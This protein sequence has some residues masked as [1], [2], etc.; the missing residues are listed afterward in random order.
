M[1]L[2]SIKSLSPHL[3]NQ[4]A[5]GEVVDRPASVVKELLE[6]ALDADADKISLEIERGGMK[7][8]R[9]RDN[10]VGIS[11]Q[12]LHLALSRHATSKISSL[13]DLENVKSLGFRGEALPSIASI[14]RLKLSSRQKEAEQAWCLYGD[15]KEIF[16][17]PPEP[18]AHPHGTSL[19]IKDLFF[20]VPARR[21]FLKTEKTEFRHIE[22]VV[23]KIALSC[24]E[25]QFSLQHN[26]RSILHLLPATDQDSADKRVASVCGKAFS[27]QSFYFEHEAA[28][29]RLWGWVGLPTFSRAQADLQYFFVNGRVIR[30]RVVSHAVRQAYQDVLYHGRHPAYVLFL[31]LEP[32]LV[33]VNAHPRK[34]EVRFR[35]S[36]LVHSFL[37]RSLKQALADLR[38]E[39][40]INDMTEQQA[41]A[42]SIDCTGANSHVNTKYTASDLSSLTTRPSPVHSYP[43]RYA[44]QN[45]GLAV[46]ETMS[47]YKQL[48]QAYQAE[49]AADATT[50]TS[51]PIQLPEHYAEQALN[52]DESKQETGEIPP[53]GFAV[54]QIQG[55]FI[56]AENALG[57]I[58]VDMHAAHE[59]IRY[60]YL[61]RSMA[62]D[63]I[64][65]QPLLVPVSLSVSEKEADY[66]EQ[67]DSI[68][69]DLG[70]NVDRLDSEKLLI[71]AVPSLLK[72]SD[73]A[74]LVTDVLSDLLMYGNSERIQAEMNTILGT[75]ACHNSVRANQT[76]SITEMNDLF[77]DMERTE[78]SGQCNHGRPTW[79]QL[80]MQQLDKLFMRGQ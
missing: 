34:Q 57:L 2:H 47:A 23:K 53:L 69:S 72:Q 14:S 62:E 52:P 70:F 13:H 45:L 40:L 36:Q 25:T 32:K 51:M 77:R 60:E 59:R 79:T 16:I 9:I 33:D 43:P 67:Y 42:N 37:H 10:G 35:E 8:I 73:V 29:L 61:K 39:H 30:D 4:I 31:E 71:R 1:S 78:R 66:A 26:G 21:K 5:A 11:Q 22:D 49:E 17:D 44:Q 28:G 80:T 58:I 20:N 68:F 64:R 6:N 76:L 3:I 41:S 12:E 15:G 38:P 27:E 19:D 74:L 18:V 46:K 56:L 48:H 7:R 65:S 24:F 63:N 75:M 50:Q 55:V 54:A